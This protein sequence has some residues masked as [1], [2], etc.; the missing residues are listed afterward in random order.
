[1]IHPDTELRYIDPAIGH[2]VFATAPIPKGTVVWTL[3]RFDRLFGPDEVRA[4]PPAYRAILDT[5]AYADAAG[6]SIL[7]W[8]HARCVNHSCE[9]SMLGLGAAFEI[10]VRDIAPGDQ[11]TCDYGGLNL[12]G[13]LRCA[14]G[15]THCRGTIAADDVLDLW[16]DWDDQVARSL[17]LAA[18]VAQPLLPF[19]G[20]TRRFWDWV[21]GR[22]P[23]PSHRDYRARDGVADLKAPRAGRG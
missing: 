13:Q 9:P 1:M 7:C 5:Y 12:H 10:A 17:P 19:A 3:C 22:A 6:N 14:C 23:M 4:L 18:H 8:D 20:D 21:H 16:Q 11:V 2:G 15:S